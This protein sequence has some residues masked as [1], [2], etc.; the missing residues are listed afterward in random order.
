VS[1]EKAE[2]VDIQVGNGLDL[3]DQHVMKILKWLRMDMN[4]M[5]VRHVEN[6]ISFPVV[7]QIKGR[8][9]STRHF[10]GRAMM[11]GG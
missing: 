9:F 3:T 10:S 4:S 1:S 6:W 5:T 7:K 2:H 11:S 8:A